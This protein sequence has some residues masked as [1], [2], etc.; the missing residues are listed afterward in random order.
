[1]KLLK[2]L[3]KFFKGN[4]MIA[5]VGFLVLLMAMYQFSK[6]KTSNVKAHMP[7]TL[8]N[9][10]EGA[11]ES[12]GQ[13]SQPANLSGHSNIAA[14]LPNDAAPTNGPN[15]MKAG[16]AIGMISQVSKNANLQ[17]R[18]EPQIPRGEGP[19]SESVIEQSPTSG[20]PEF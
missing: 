1:M 18:A 14:L 3:D 19:R 13:L 2:Q 16:A 12:E 5:I 9:G 6:R 17:L 11:M 15:M 4:T 20:F 7:K 8:S 10:P